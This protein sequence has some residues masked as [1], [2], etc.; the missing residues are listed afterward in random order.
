MRILVSVLLVLLLVPGYSVEP[1]RPMIG[2][3][4]SIEARPV[5]LVEGDHTR[6]RLGALTYLGGV[7]LRSATD[8]FGGFSAIDVQ[9]DKFTLLS[10][11]G[12]VIWFRL[13]RTGQVAEPG[14]TELPAGP[15]AGWLKRDR[16]SE[17]LARDPATGS[18]LVGFE[19]ANA[20]WRYD[21]GFK[22]ALGHASP[23][24]MRD[25]P[26]NLGAE[27]VVHMPGGGHIVISED[28]E[29]P[30]KHTRAALYFSGDPVKAPRKGFRFGYRVPRGFSPSDATLLPDGR[31]AVLDRAFS[32]AKGFRVK[33]AIIDPADIRPGA[34]V[35]GK[36]VATFAAPVIHDNFEGVTATR[37]GAD[38]ILWMV[39]DDN[40]SI[41]QRTLL[42]K[43]RLDLPAK[44][45][46][47]PSGD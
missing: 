20:L 35:S 7:E 16:D 4:R 11:L 24:A 40:Q 1:L 44:A 23:P 28:G 5:S 34:T 29:W 26:D 42:L 38:T 25:W 19:N 41:F 6:R 2:D 47:K 39:S 36:V 10:D 30:G 33:L 31:I 27:S 17:S 37:E 18:F 8:G 22:R 46:A 15:G 13:T 3:L 45:A 21:A 12:Y 14:A 9:G 32:V 43:F